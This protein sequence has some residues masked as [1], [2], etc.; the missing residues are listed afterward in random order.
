MAAAAIIA[1]RNAK[2]KRDEHFDNM[3][4]EEMAE[5]D[6]KRRREEEEANKPKYNKEMDYELEGRHPHVK[7]YLKHVATPA[8]HIAINET[9]CR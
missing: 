9:L 1:M 3:T 5:L 6:A 4:D 7:A 8:Y 2:K